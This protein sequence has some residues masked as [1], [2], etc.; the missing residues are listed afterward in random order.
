MNPILAIVGGGQLGRMLVEAAQKIKVNTV[1]LDPTPNSPAGQLTTQ[2]VGDYKNYSDVKKLAGKAD[3]LTFEVEGANAQ[4]L[5]E[6]Q[7]AKLPVNPSPSTLEMI[8]DKFTQK[9][10]LLANN[11]PVVEFTGV[12]SRKDIIRTAKYLGYPLVLKARFGGFDG[13]GNIVIKRE[14]DIKSALSKMAGQKLYIEKYIPFAK[15]IAIQI[16]RD[17]QGKT[18]PYPI[19]ETIQKNNI[20]HVVK[21]PPK[22][23]AKV[24]NKAQEIAT[25]VATLMSGSGV[26]AIEMFVTKNGNVVVNEIAPRVHNS[27]HW[28]IEGAKTSQFENHVRAVCNL[29]IKSTSPTTKSAVMINILGNRN[30]TSKP[31]NAQQIEKSYGVFVHIYGKFETKPDRKMGH[32]T[33]L[34]ANL[35][36]TYKKALTARKAISI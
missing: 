11:I 14:S 19:V 32:I 24:L 17:S 36:T 9:T 22:V 28:T 27:G 5:Q 10:F 20:C 15:E 26:F 12:N 16:V 6:M 8:Q 4:G 3:F 29:P 33:A 31:I 25:K 34:G 1:V 35:E 18:Y 2:I 21:Y 13:R 23:S 30:G 7:A